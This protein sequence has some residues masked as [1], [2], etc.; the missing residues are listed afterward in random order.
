MP[1]TTPARTLLDLA[2]VLTPRQLERAVHEPQYRRLTSPLP[3]MPCSR[4]TADDG[5]GG[6]EGVQTRGYNVLGITWRGRHDD[7]TTIATQLRAL[8]AGRSRRPG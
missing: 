8:L 1:V 3:S 2:E 4:A 6:T 7:V 5:D